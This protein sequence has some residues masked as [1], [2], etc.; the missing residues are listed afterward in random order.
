[1]IEAAGTV[2]DA[3]VETA[4]PVAS[5]STVRELPTPPSVEPVVS[6]TPTK[7]PP[8]TT[9]RVDL[10]T[11]LRRKLVGIV[12][13]RNINSPGS[14]LSECRSCRHAR[15]AGHRAPR[16]GPG[17]NAI[18]ALDADIARARQRPSAL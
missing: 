18:R 8:A 3:G 13:Q 7:R 11:R 14:A 2:V 9:A 15:R 17:Q 10:V 1:M 4:A 5:L 16:S 6:P 12:P